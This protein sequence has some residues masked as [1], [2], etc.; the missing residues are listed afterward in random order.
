MYLSEPLREAIYAHS[1]SGTAFLHVPKSAG[2]AVLGAL[3]VRHPVLHLDRVGGAHRHGCPCRAAECRARAR[4]ERTFLSRLRQG[5]AWV[6]NL[7]QFRLTSEE[8]RDI[9]AE[10][11]II[12]PLRNSA[13]RLVSY[14]RYYWTM[15]EAAR[16]SRVLV[17]RRH[18]MT[19]M[20]TPGGTLGNI[21]RF[22][23]DPL[24]VSEVQRFQFLPSTYLQNDGYG[25]RWEEWLDDALGEA[26]SL[27]LYSD[28][29]PD[30]LSPVDPR[31]SRLV[32]MRIPEVVRWVE[33]D[34]GTRVS[35]RNVSRTSSRRFD[36]EA[37]AARLEEVAADLVAGDSEIWQALSLQSRGN[38]GSLPS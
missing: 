1:S 19:W 7:G 29:L 31:W 25:I 33:E 17:T 5:Q 6:L 3:E 14:F 24:K 13:D 8:A 32:P 30:M 23:R 12:V 36:L 4:H 34:L 28:L 27:F 35:L 2:S 11:P 20:L 16:H 21:P 22:S 10:M 9:P 15:A 38:P 37:A 18:A 26:S